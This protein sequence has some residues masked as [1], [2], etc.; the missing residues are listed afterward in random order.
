MPKLINRNPK[1]SKLRKYAVA[2]Y[3]GNIH[4]FGLHGTPEAL[5]AY[6]RFCAELQ[7][8]PIVSL[9][10]GEK[11]V[12]I[13]ELTVAFLDHAKASTDRTEFGH[14]RTIVLD[15][16]DKLY[17]DNF[18]VDDFKPRDLKLVREEMAKSRRFCRK[19]VNGYT[20]RIVSM[21]AWGV[22]HDLVPISVL[23]S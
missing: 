6:N 19:T 13:R 15:F 22:E 1:L 11:H 17:G 4:Y 8:N 5:S 10:R 16:L 18:P 20:R 9:P 21:F 7:A 3:R 12:T 2:Y 23:R 14:L